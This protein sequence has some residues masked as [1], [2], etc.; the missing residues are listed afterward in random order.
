MQLMAFIVA[1]GDFWCNVK[2]RG[3]TRHEKGHTKRDGDG[4]RQRGRKDDF[5]SL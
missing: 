4:E 3:D 5:L 2:R 1:K